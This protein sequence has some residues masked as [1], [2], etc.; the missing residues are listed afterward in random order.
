MRCP[1]C[2]APQ[3]IWPGRFGEPR[4]SPSFKIDGFVPRVSLLFAEEVRHSPA[5]RTCTHAS[6]TPLS[7]SLTP[8]SLSLSPLSRTLT[9]S[10]LSHLLTPL[11]LT[12][13]P[14]SPRQ[15]PPSAHPA[16]RGPSK[17]PW[18]PLRATCVKAAPSLPPQVNPQ[19]QDLNPA[20]C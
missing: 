15:A 20:P 9:H 6:L 13:T 2:S 10:A 18:P 16:S 12:H 14:L 19:P 1:H 3:P 4:I 7:R 11:S 17:T 5:R 8:L